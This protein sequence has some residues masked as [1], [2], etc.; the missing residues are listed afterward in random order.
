MIYG[1]FYN[2]V[3]LFFKKQLLKNFWLRTLHVVGIIYVAVITFLDKYCPLTILEIY[4][5]R[6]IESSFSGM[7]SFIVYY[8]EKLIYPE[9]NPDLI[10]VPTYLIAILSLVIYIIKPPINFQI[11]RP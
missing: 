10:I 7:D 6:K 5:R 4:L 8:L 3:G 2:I 11:R 9:V 1:F